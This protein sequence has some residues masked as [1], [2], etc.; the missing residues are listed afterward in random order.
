MQTLELP[1]TVPAQ[2]PLPQGLPQQAG[3]LHCTLEQDRLVD[4]PG[5]V[6]LLVVA[7]PPLTELLLC[8]PVAVTP[9]VAPELGSPG[10]A[11]EL[12]GLLQPFTV[13]SIETAAHAMNPNWR[14]SICNQNN[15]T[16]L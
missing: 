10:L 14:N 8:V 11:S 3:A 2:Q 7:A 4:T 6:V 9:P 16:Q 13:I 15:T 12:L 1:H 5:P